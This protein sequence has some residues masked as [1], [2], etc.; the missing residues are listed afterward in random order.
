MFDVVISPFGTIS[1]GRGEMI[2]S[3]KNVLLFRIGIQ[4][5]IPAHSIQNEWYHLL[6]ISTHISQYGVDVD[7]FR[8]DCRFSTQQLTWWL[9]REMMLTT[10]SSHVTRFE[11]GR[12]SVVHTA[13]KLC[14]THRSYPPNSCSSVRFNLHDESLF[15]SDS[16]WR[17]PC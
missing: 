16:C 5:Q 8:V 9:P 15:A 12:R 11:V 4:E 2:F 1:V 3:K 10:R 17:L 6:K 13:S 7:K 14:R